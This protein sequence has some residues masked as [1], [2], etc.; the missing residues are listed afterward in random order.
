LL[1]F[2]KYQQ[3]AATAVDLSNNAHRKLLDVI[4]QKVYKPT[5]SQTGKIYDAYW[6]GADLLTLRV[7]V[8]FIQTYERIFER[9]VLEC[10]NKFHGY[11]LPLV[12]IN[13]TRLVLDVLSTAPLS[14]P[15]D[16]D[17][18]SSEEGN[19]I[20]IILILERH[21][22]LIAS[23][24]LRNIQ[25]TNIFLFLAPQSPQS[26]V[27]DTYCIVFQLF[28]GLWQEKVGSI[29]KL[30]GLIDSIKKTMQ[31][32]LTGTRKILISD[33]KRTLSDMTTFAK[34]KPASVQEK[35]K[36]LC[37]DLKKLKFETDQEEII[38]TLKSIELLIVSHIQILHIL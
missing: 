4:I 18:L 30:P 20:F 28:E 35:F 19:D 17:A 22:Y 7:L 34:K 14:V 5:S 27:E 29:P 23:E 3:E 9:I 1:W 26:L 37:A 15:Q 33:F 10:T 2:Q 38:N 21:Y 24:S 11:L 31:T 36:Q 32:N 25:L 8:Y 12:S 16:G 6:I 13:L